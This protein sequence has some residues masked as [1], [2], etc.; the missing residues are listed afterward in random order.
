MRSSFDCYRRTMRKLRVKCFNLGSLFFVQ[1]RETQ[2]L[3]PPLHISHS[4][5]NHLLHLF[6]HFNRIICVKMFKIVN[7]I[8][9]HKWT[10]INL[11]RVQ[12]NQPLF[13]WLLVFKR[14]EKFIISRPM[15][16]IYAIIFIAVQLGTESVVP[17]RFCYLFEQ[18]MGVERAATFW[19]IFSIL[20]RST[21]TKTTKKTPRTHTHT[22]NGF[23]ASVYYSLVSNGIFLM[24]YWIA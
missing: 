9:H 21:K 6:A 17:L 2:L 3:P 24:L 19:W 15:H 8:W 22:K 20:T 18:W 16:S 1:S 4:R 5:I 14:R 10:I 13:S 7:C 23:C 12:L 11:F